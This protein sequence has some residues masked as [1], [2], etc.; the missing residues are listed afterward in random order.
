MYKKHPS[1]RNGNYGSTTWLIF[2]KVHISNSWVLHFS[3]L[4]AFPNV[5]LL[6]G[7]A[8]TAWEPSRQENVSVPPER[9]PLSLLPQFSLL[10]FSFIQIWKDQSYVWIGDF[11]VWLDDEHCH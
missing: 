2:N 3:D 9:S 5:H 6:E 10:P 7:Q 8:G 4:D 11:N 1:K